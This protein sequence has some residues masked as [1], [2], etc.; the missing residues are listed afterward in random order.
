MTTELQVGSIFRGV[1]LFYAVDIV[2]RCRSCVSVSRECGRLFLISRRTRSVA[3][4]DCASA[5]PQYAVHSSVLLDCAM[6]SSYRS[7]EI[8]LPC[9]NSGQSHLTGIT[10]LY[11]R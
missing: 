1:V 8:A 7:Y 9:I 5:R 10:G 6:D 2:R 4:Q 3:I 11:F